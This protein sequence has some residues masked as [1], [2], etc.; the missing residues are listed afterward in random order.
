MQAA[1]QQRLFN[2]NCEDI[3]RWLEESEQ[4]LASEDVGKD[5]ASVN[6]LLKNYQVWKGFV[7]KICHKTRFFAVYQLDL[8]CPVV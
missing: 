7:M 2:R 5:L 8:Q 6:E 3:E 4:A 1:W